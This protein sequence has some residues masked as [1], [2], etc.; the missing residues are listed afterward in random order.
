[1]IWCVSG[2][3]AQPLP[4]R[5]RVARP[6]VAARNGIPAAAS[7][8]SLPPSPAQYTKDVEVNGFPRSVQLDDTAGQVSPAPRRLSLCACGGDRPGHPCIAY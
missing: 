3:K 7:S 6:C 8:L 1:M 5:L 4:G 2:W